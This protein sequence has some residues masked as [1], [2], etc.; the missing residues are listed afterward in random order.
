MTGSSEHREVGRRS[1]VADAFRAWGA[2]VAERPWAVVAGATAVCVG[3][4]LGL[5]GAVLVASPE[6][7]WAPEG[8]ELT[9][10]KDAFE[11]AFGRFFRVESLVV[12]AKDGGGVLAAAPLAE[13]WRLQQVVEAV[14]TEDGTPLGDMC[15]QPTGASCVVVSPLDYWGAQN[16]A[17]GDMRGTP[18]LC[19]PSYADLPAAV[20]NGAKSPLGQ[21]LVVRNLWGGVKFGADGS[22]V[23]SAQAGLITVLLDY[24]RADEVTMRAWEGAFVDAVQNFESDV[25]RVHVSSERSLEDEI[26][27]EASTDAV[28][29][30]VSYAIV[31]AFVVVSLGIRLAPY[32]IVGMITC[33]VALLS[34]A[35]F[36]ALCGVPLTPMTFQVLPFLTM[37]VG[38]NGSFVFLTGKGGQALLDPGTSAVERVSECC[39]AAAPSVFLAGSTNAVAFFIGCATILPGVR[40]FCLQAA[41]AV[42]FVVALQLTL[43][44]AVLAIGESHWGAAEE[45]RHQDDH[46]GVPGKDAALDVEEPHGDAG[47]KPLGGVTQGMEAG[48]K[49]GAVSNMLRAAL[50]GKTASLCVL[51]CFAGL[52]GAAGY[53]AS[54]VT[55]GLDAQEAVPRGSYLVSFY[56]SLF[57]YFPNTGPLVYVITGKIDYSNLEVQA[58]VEQLSQR[59]YDSKETSAAPLD[60]YNDLRVWSGLLGGKFADMDCSG[61][62][63]VCRM[64]D[65]DRF[66]EWMQEFLGTGCDYSRGEA[67]GRVH[68]ENIVFDPS[69]PT[70]R[71]ILTTRIMS[72]YG[73]MRS[74][75]EFVDGMQSIR[76]LASDAD[77][78]S[79]AY[80]SYYIFFE[81][82]LVSLPEAVRNL[83]FAGLACYVLCITFFWGEGSAILEAGLLSG[84][85]LICLITIVVLVVALMA[86]WDVKLNALSIVNLVMCFGL[87]VDFCV[88]LARAFS[89]NV[90]S[91]SIGGSDGQSHLDPRAGRVVKALEDV[92]GAIL[93]G[94]MSTFCGTVV[95]FFARYPVFEIYYARMYVLIIISGLLGGLVLLPALLRV[96]P[97]QCTDA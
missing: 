20:R 36:L 25:I 54:R 30:I 45:G 86:A 19:G 3:L 53:G 75:V 74:A 52:L 71:T 50:K 40:A 32:G 42:L 15:F 10:E 37:G 49:R 43:V 31:L 46:L 44:P 87:G 8:S 9:R 14:K 58:R 59:F 17:E 94:G 69:D 29:V 61:A 39:A 51:V 77:L 4:S 93:S 63:G 21:G 85:V 91:T 80:S 28:L 88:H 38:I 26:A 1:I 92:G 35:G 6:G 57:E 76:S 12:E 33:V 23:V 97:T 79:F 67:C 60:W 47:E 22:T 62:D 90:S 83:L 68:R 34:A 18:S 48:S 73:G 27:R 55:M 56:D 16:C 24:K 65:D 13:L 64:P 78:D 82:Y 72:Q 41:V 70:N 95:L 81:Q 66:Y 11:A 89:V 7:L 84:I 2:G 96:V 5:L